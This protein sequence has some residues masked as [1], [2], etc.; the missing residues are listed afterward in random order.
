MFRKITIVI[1]PLVILLMI[2]G[3][4]IYPKVPNNLFCF[5]DIGTHHVPPYM[6]GLKKGAIGQTFVSNFDNLFRIAI[7]LS[8]RNVNRKAILRFRLRETAGEQDIVTKEWNISNIKPVHNSFYKI[9][10]DINVDK[11]FHYHIQFTPIKDSRDKSFYFYFETQ[12]LIEGESINFGIWK[13]KY[14]E[15]MSEGSLFVNGK[16]KDDFL[17][18]RSYNTWTGNM[19]DVFREVRRRLLLDKVFFFFYVFLLF[20][21]LS[22]LIFTNVSRKIF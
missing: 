17:A 21:T 15:A 8:N 13:R 11:G 14:Y 20:F 4:Y 12:G 6:I 10:P 9:P 2:L 1:F 7:F 16:P 22:G 5:R 19:N 3:C 18:F